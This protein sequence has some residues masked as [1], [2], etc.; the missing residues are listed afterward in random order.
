MSAP[1]K[2]EIRPVREADLPAMA[3]IEATLQSFPWTSLQFIQSYAEGHRGWV[4]EL[5]GEVI[6]FAV[7]SQVL[8]EISLLTLGVRPDHQR[9]GLARLML[10]VI[11]EQ[12][13]EEGAAVMILE[14]RKGNQAA[15]SLYKRLGFIENGLRKGYYRAADGREDAVL[16]AL[17][18]DEGGR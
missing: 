13:C 7:T 18:L 2:P 8:D 5:D 14:V 11:V 3:Q 15:R 10:G 12:A 17:I 4:A 1:F 6:G 16:M 9:R